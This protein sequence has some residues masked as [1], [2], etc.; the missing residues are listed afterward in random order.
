MAGLFKSLAAV[1]VVAFA[2]GFL[3]LVIG[4][5]FVAA[6]FFT[7]RFGFAAISA[8]RAFTSFFTIAAGNG[9][10][11]VNRIVPL[12]VLNPFSASPNAA[13]A[14]PLIGYKAQCFAHTPTAI[15]GRPSTLKVGSP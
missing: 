4:V 13:T 1:L 14:L 15:S 2:T 7:P 11:A 10:S 12:L 6:A 3:A 9:F 5:A 8:S